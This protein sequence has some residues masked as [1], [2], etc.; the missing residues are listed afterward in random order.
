VGLISMNPAQMEATVASVRATNQ[1]LTALYEELQKQVAVLGEA[2]S[3]GD[4]Q[5]YQEYQVQWNR[6]HTDLADALTQIGQGVDDA[7]R[8][9]TSAVRANAT[10]WRR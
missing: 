7:S 6:L 10:V 1:R 3:G 8:R 9:M 4:Q 2:W 5:A